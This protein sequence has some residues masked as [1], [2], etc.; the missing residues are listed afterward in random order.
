MDYDLNDLPQELLER[1]S[2][3]LPRLVERRPPSRA[4]AILGV[5]FARS[6]LFQASPL[7]AQLEYASLLGA[8][9]YEKTW[10]P[11]IKQTIRVA[12][13]KVETDQV[14]MLAIA[15]GSRIMDWIWRHARPCYEPTLLWYGDHGSSWK[16]QT[17]E[18]QNMV[19]YPLTKIGRRLIKA[20]LRRAKYDPD[21]G[22]S[23]FMRI[24]L[25]MGRTAQSPTEDSMHE[26]REM[27]AQARVIRISMYE[28]VRMAFNETGGIWR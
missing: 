2:S 8:G 17:T 13:S 4:E 16:Y 18:S 27:R 20:D 26:L 11:K 14:T 1:P 25:I 24:H 10:G 12:T 22:D 28:A 5:Y 19:L 21:G 3:R 6:G 9:Q 15:S 23:A 7:G